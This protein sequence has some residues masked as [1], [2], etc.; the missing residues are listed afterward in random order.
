MNDCAEKLAILTGSGIHDLDHKSMS[1]LCDNVVEG[2]NTLNT[3]RAVGLLS[4]LH[5]T[6]PCAN[7][8]QFSFSLPYHS[9]V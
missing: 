2:P 3:A 4:L 9:D 1:G 8:W 5:S 6:F 7:G